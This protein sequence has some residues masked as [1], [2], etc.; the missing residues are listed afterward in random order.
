MA[1]AE[2]VNIPARRWR[3]AKWKENIKVENVQG[4]K[5]VDDE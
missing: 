5:E 2:S 1:A 4:V 3:G